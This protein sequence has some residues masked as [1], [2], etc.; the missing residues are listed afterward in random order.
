M[1]VAHQEVVAHG[2]KLIDRIVA[3][4]ESAEFLGELTRIPA[5]TLDARELSDLE[6]IATGAASPLDG[7]MGSADYRSVLERIRLAD[8]TVWPLPM[9]IAVGPH[10][11]KYVEAGR[12]IALRD[13]RGRFWG[14]IH[15]R[16]VYQREAISEARAVYRT[17]DPS[18]PGVAYVQSRPSLLIG[19]PVKMLPL[20]DDLPFAGYR[21]S[22]RQLRQQI[23]ARG[24]RRVAGFQTRNPIHRAHEH[25]TKLALEFVDGL[26]IHPLIGET[27]GDDVPADVRFRCYQ[28][29]V[30]KYYPKDRVLLAA[31]PAAM[32]YAGPREALFHALIRKNYGIQHLIV[33]RDHAGVKKF[34]GPFE[35]QG[36]FDHFSSEELAVEPLRFDAM[37][38]CRSCENLAS[39]RSCPHPN[40]QRLELSGTQVRQILRTGGRLPPEFSRHEVA[41]ILRG[42][43]QGTGEPAASPSP[44][45]VRRGFIVWFT[46]LSAAGKTTLAQELSRRLEPGRTVHVLDGDEIRRQLSRD[47]GFSKAD[48][49]ANIRRLGYVAILLA[50]KDA[51]AV[52]AAISPYAEVR[53]EIRRAAEEQAIPFLEIYVRADLN[54]LIER[55][56]KGLYRK[57]LAG[58]IERFT[59][60]SDPYEAPEGPALELRTDKETIAQSTD[61]I[62]Q[63]L[64]DRGLLI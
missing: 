60:I 5:L 33:G 32:R 38:Y 63:L 50:Q 15:V 55:D 45:P 24:W 17:E 57:A 39:A 16:E 46:G 56:P 11:A 47:L 58:E 14:S 30:D 6:L 10:D 8:G 54:I 4:E 48:R 51:I 28:A 44:R 3:E 42:H 64:H 25:L 26:V 41:E 12:R 37:F 52:C 35:A 23:A 62:A 18:H 43:Y 27:S 49:D 53:N 13:C 59:G 61:R 7:F 9:N 36:I 1:L 19:G 29:L 21:F 31:F 40:E 34:Y 20:P 22:P 2:G